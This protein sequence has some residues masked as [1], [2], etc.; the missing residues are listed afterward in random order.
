MCRRVREL[1]CCERWGLV[2]LRE[3]SVVVAVMRGF[4]SGSVFACLVPYTA[5]FVRFKETTCRDDVSNARHSDSLVL[6]SN[7]AWG[8]D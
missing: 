1:L 6:A 4:E 2:V 8:C 7:T 3:L 5:N